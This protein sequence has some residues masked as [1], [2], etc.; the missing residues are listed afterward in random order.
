MKE[1]A[2]TLAPEGRAK[3]NEVKHA[4]IEGVKDRLEGAK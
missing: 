3:H 1:Q 4:F 2:T